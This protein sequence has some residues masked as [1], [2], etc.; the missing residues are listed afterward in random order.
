MLS[1]EFIQQNFPKGKL[2][3][4]SG[5]P[6]SGKTS[7]GISLAMT[8]VEAKHNPIFFSMETPKANVVSRA[9]FHLKDVQTTAKVDDL[10]IDDTPSCDVNYVRQVVEANSVDFVIIDYLQLMYADECSSREE[11]MNKI[12]NELQTLASERN[13]PVV[14][15]SQLRRTAQ[16][17]A[18]CYVQEKDEVHPAF[19]IT[20]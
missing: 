11:E 6:A 8:L 20:N 15:I 3:T 2:T 12:T 1:L 7:F 4:V 10:L 5:R 9:K 17:K 16:T 14:V 19:M 18:F 13:I